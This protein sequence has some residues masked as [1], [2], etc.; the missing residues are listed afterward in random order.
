MTQFQKLRHSTG[1]MTLF[2]GVMSATVI[3]LSGTN[4]LAQTPA[5]AP[6]S[7]EDPMLAASRQAFEALPETERKAI[8]DALT[9]AG[10]Y[11]ATSG[12]T[13][14][15]QT[16]N[17]INAYQKS[18][19]L[20]VNGILSADNLAKLKAAAAAKKNAAGFRVVRDARS[21]VEIGVPLTLLPKNQGN[22]AFGGNRWQSNDGKITLDTRTQ[23]GGVEEFQALYERNTQSSPARK[24]TYKLQRP[25]FFVVTGETATGEF[26][27]RYALGTEGVRG[28]TLAYDKSAKADFNRVMIAI[29]NSFTPFP[30]A[31]APA[32][33]GT[34]A[35]SAAQ[36]PS[37]ASNA[38]PVAEKPAAPAEAVPAAQAA[39]VDVAK[40]STGIRVGPRQIVTAGLACKNPVIA[41]STAKIV[42]Q[43]GDLSLLEVASDKAV[44]ALPVR[45]GP[46]PEGANLVVVAWDA[47][48]RSAGV[49]SGQSGGRENVTAALQPGGQGGLVFDRSGAVVGVIGAAKSPLRVI[50]GVATAA[51]YPVIAATS[52]QELIG[53]NGGFAGEP[54]Q[55]TAQSTGAIAADAS[56]RIV[57]ITCP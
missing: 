30:A 10:V 23:P 45:T 26:Y 28:F 42:K 39:P 13:F 22:N 51:T 20:P 7:A 50:S 41:G 2:A 54:D 4:T 24:V 49:V 34:D 57:D 46:V 25:D 38:K 16:Y 37:A 29:A 18:A 27:V 17:G 43:N 5:P 55:T 1:M 14:G 47:P 11:N 19:G 35:P 31:D 3:V 8:Q 6:V 48:S 52:V 40:V 32:P 56:A 36:S 53:G 33:A 44:V 9:W 15:R 12:G 21:G